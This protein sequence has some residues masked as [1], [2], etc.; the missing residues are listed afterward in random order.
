MRVE[1]R[2]R[3]EEADARDD[4]CRDARRVTVRTPVRGEA[5][6]GDADREMCEERRADTDEDVR[7]KARGLARDFTLEANRAAEKGGEQELE[8]QHELEGVAHR[9]ERSGLEQL[10]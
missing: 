1:D 2:P 3:A 5:D 6:L 4:L 9:T 7:A 8:K 10:S